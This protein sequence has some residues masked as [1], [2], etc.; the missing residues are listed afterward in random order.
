VG[1]GSSLFLR[2]LGEL[3]DELFE[4]L[5]VIL[6]GGAAGVGDGEQGMGFFGDKFFFDLYVLGGIFI[7]SFNTITYA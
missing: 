5:A 3:F 4:V 7:S 2:V 6:E 1:I